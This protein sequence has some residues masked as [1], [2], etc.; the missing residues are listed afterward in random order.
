MDSNFSSAW[1]FLMKQIK[2]FQASSL[3][4]WKRREMWWITITKK[5]GK[6]MAQNAKP[7]CHNQNLSS[8]INKEQVIS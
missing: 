6:Q 4:D 3:I 2:L 8:C 7:N 1:K 5:N